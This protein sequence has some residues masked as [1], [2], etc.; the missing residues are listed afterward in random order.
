MGTCGF[1][2]EE[3]DSV[4]FNQQLS[5]HM[6]IKRAKKYAEEHNVIDEREENA[7]KW[8]KMPPYS[9]KKG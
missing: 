4:D 6:K 7:K 2:D 3:L 5:L 1:E 8:F 9:I